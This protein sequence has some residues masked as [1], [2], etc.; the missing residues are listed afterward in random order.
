MP[1][2]KTDYLIIGSGAMGMAFADTLITETD[3]D[4]IIVDRYAKPGGH[5]NHAYPFVTLH[6]PSQFYGVSSKELSQER[7][8]Q[9]GLNK[10]MFDLASGAEVSAYY[11]D[12]MQHTFLTSGRVRYFPLCDYT[13]D[14]SFTS[15]IT[16]ETY[17]VDVKDKLVDATYLKTNVPS[18][19]TPSFKVAPDVNFMPLNDLPS[20]ATAPEGFVVIG[21]GKTGVDACLWLLEQKVHPE[22]ITWVISRD[23]WMLDRQNSQPTLAFFEYSLGTIARQFEAIASSTSVE[24]MFDKLEEVGMFV[25]LDKAHRPSMFHGATVSQLELAELRKIRN[26]IRFGRVQEILEDTIILDK[27]SIPTSKNHVHVDCSASAITNLNTKPIFEEGLIT[28]QTV[29]AYQ[30][31]F[32]ASV[33]AYIEANYTTDKEKNNLCQV[34]PLPNHDTDWIPMTATQMVNQI[35]W[36]QDKHLRKWIR[37]NRL[38]GFSSMISQIEKSDTAKLDILT[39]IKNGGLP[40]MMKLREY[41]AQLQ[42]THNQTT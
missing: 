11:D 42:S 36:A 31:V 41:M 21:G 15:L 22:K 39:R 6:Q 30:P 5:W 12:V 18:L 20:I 29:R 10:G 13:G 8:D 32:S 34:V 38:D 26:V 16:G 2:L 40:A 23:A 37:G 24:D 4:I 9:V 25:R 14:H 7:I 27:G 1:K 19:H 3:S 33:A 35:T 17:Q 28:P